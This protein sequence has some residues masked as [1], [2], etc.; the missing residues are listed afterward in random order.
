M[1]TINYFTS[2]L[3]TLATVPQLWSDYHDEAEA[4][5]R[6][7]GRDIDEIIVEWMEANEEADADNAESI[8]DKY[9]LQFF[10]VTLRPGYYDGL[11]ILIDLDGYPD[12]LDDG[13]RHAILDKLDDLQKALEELAGVGFVETFPGWCTGYSDYPET[14]KAIRQAIEAERETVKAIPAWTPEGWTA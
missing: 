3:I 12:E 6:E 1:G 11:Q 4:E 8:L 5:A 2:D 13:E 14:I 9:N 10:H 7:T